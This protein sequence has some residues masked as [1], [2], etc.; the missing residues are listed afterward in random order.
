[1]A[2][3]ATG[4]RIRIS[5]YQQQMIGIVL[6]AAIVL[7]AAVVLSIFFIKYII[8]NSKVIEGK[9]AA[10]A[11]YNT[12]MKNAE[13]LRNEVLELADNK[14]LESVA[15]GT[16]RECYDSDGK[17]KDFNEL[18]FEAQNEE[19]A[20]ELL[21][22]MR[23]CSAL[24]VIPDALPA[25]RNDE[26]LMSSLDQI[27]KLSGWE[28]ESLSPSGTTTESEIAGLEVIPVSL[29]VEADAETTFRVLDNIERSIRSIDV[30]DA[31]IAWSGSDLELRAQAS[32]Y[33]TEDVGVEEETKV[34]YA[35]DEARKANK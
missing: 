12:A 13:V 5:K 31:V 15:Q 16:A 17:K 7:G 28:P 3:Q 32:A 20:A 23:K 34:I 6:V 35:S 14:A 30:S 22:M 9:D 19:E 10:I 33:Y 8:F 18:Y 4:K 29:A 1:M 27:F 24:R 25:H 26:A 11:G 21:K 2:K